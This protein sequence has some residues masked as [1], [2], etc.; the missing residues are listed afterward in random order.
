M[1]AIPLAGIKVLEFSH[2]VMGPTAGL[3]FAELGADVIKIEPAPKG[4]HTRGLGGFGAGFFAAFNRNKRS[5]AVDLKRKEG[6]TVIHRLV[7]TADVILE[8]FGPGTMERL[9]CGY[10]QLA[11]LNP[12]LVYLALKGYLA[13][14]YEHRPA[15]DEVVQFQTGL[16]FMTGPPGEP[17]RAGASVID[18]MGAVFGVVAAQAALRERD[19]SGR[20][21]R[22]S[23]AL[24]E[25]AAFLMSTH[26]AGMAATGLEARPMPARRGA[27]AVYEV[28]KTAAAGQLF[29]GVTSDQ[30]WT[31][32][33]EEFGLQELAADP[34]LATNVTRLAERAWLIPALREVLA[35]LP[36]DEV[37]RRCERCNVSWAPV[38]QPGDLFTD[39]HLLATGGLV[40]V[41]IS[42]FGG[43]DG[44]F[45]GLPALPV[46]FGLDRRRPG[47]QRQPPRMGEHNAELLSEAGFSAAEIARL[48]AAGVIAARTGESG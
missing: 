36:Q 19:I 18:I 15:L 4:D 34:R 20:G 39:P 33:V 8:N 2:T 27:W 5:L 11:A 45:A 44:K 31:R 22:V 40:D 25:S 42:R 38:G 47:I 48:V 35:T 14:P 9:G 30:Q 17:L 7:P 29:I 46:E 23:S 10:E 12:R 21:Q 28:F 37:A 13:G 16:A 41:F 26:M 6:Q 1:S 43:G 32:F 3:V 24:F